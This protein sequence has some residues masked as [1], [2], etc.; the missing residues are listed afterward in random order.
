MIVIIKFETRI[1]TCRNTIRN[2]ELTALRFRNA[3]PTNNNGVDKNKDEEETPE[4]PA[5][6]LGA[7]MLSVNRILAYKIVTEGGEQKPS[8]TGDTEHK[9]AEDEELHMQQGGIE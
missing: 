9:N 3:K 1:S 4:R 7:A 8:W 6:S 5:R 2:L